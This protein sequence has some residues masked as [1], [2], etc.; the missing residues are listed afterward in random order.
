MP[1]IEIRSRDEGHRFE[2]DSGERILYGGLRSGL[3]LPYECATGTCG[4]CKARLLDGELE[5][6]WPDAPGKDLLKPNS[7]DFLMCQC[8][9]KGSGAVTAEVSKPVARLQADAH[10]PGWAKGVV[11]QAPRYLT[12]DVMAVDVQLDRPVRFEAGQFMALEVADVPGTR[13][14]SMVNYATET[15][16]LA[17]VIKRKPGGGVS[18]WLFG[19]DRAG[20]PVRL[21]GPLGTALFRPEMDTN[22]LCIAGGTGI[23][24]IMSI[25]QRACDEQYFDNHRGD[26]FFGVRTPADAF[27]LDELSTFSRKF[28][29]TLNI[30]VAF[31]D[32]P[33]DD[34][35]KRKHGG[36]HFKEG[37]VHEVAGTAMADR[38]QGLTA[39]LAGPPPAVE[40]SV[41]LLVMSRV[42]PAN[43]RYDKFS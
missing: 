3:D 22:I 18:E 1:A 38:L 31:S 14:Y 36:I 16:R 32:Q 43:I 7:G 42:S 40:A 30:T 5:E 33:A 19:G 41:R 37:F 28:P 17:F 9:P 8:V 25:L 39:Y 6:L 21:F 11:I 24:G 10:A 34:A 23:A 12:H 2:V 29:Q 13:G 26:V 35:F 27:Y 15:D 20:T 4:S